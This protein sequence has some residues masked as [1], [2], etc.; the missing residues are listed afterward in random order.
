MENTAGMIEEQMV[1]K[2]LHGAYEYYPRITR[3]PTNTFD[4]PNI[5]L[6]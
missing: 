3:I 6:F 2:N 4:K 1:K 5:A